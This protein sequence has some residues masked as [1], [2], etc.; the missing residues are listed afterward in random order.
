MAC[1]MTFSVMLLELLDAGYKR[2]RDYLRETP[3]AR[4]AFVIHQEV[5]QVTVIIKLNHFAVLTTD[6][7]Y[8][9]AGSRNRAPSP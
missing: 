3:G 5:A 4:R 2:A 1:G 7:D 8:R 9:V 6:V